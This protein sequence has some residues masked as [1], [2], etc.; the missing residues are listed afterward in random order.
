MEEV[1]LETGRWLFRDL[2]NRNGTACI[3]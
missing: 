2:W 1:G 3:D